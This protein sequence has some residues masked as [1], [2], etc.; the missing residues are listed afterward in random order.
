MTPSHPKYLVALSKSHHAVDIDVNY[1]ILLLLYSHNTH[2]VHKSHNG[3]AFLYNVLDIKCS[4]RS[5]HED[6]L[7]HSLLQSNTTSQV[8][9][10]VNCNV[11]EREAARER[12]R[13]RAR[14]RE[15][16]GQRECE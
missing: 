14:D 13:E 4:N 11:V 7:L 8:I 1:A 10:K 6:A 3:N 15:R 16:E 2:L 12:E 5:I 9:I